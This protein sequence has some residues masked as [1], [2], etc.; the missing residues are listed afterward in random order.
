MENVEIRQASE[1]DREAIW[2]IFHAIVVG[3]DTY[4]FDPSIPKEEALAYWMSPANEKF[5]AILNDEVV[6]TYILRAN[7]PGLG[8]HVANAAFMVNPEA[9]RAGIGK[10][11]G[12]HALRMARKFGY[13]AMQFNFVVSTN[14][15]AIALWK[16]LGFEIVGILPGAFRHVDLGYVDALV[17]YQVL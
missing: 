17:M 16:K 6:G 7:Q 1:S 13:R 2:E 11:M 3:A 10:A 5:V 9:R 8:S 14:E 12:E 4:V 15:R